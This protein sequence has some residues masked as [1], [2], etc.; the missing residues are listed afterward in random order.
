MH[1][2][3]STFHIR[4][5]T[6]LIAI[7]LLSVLL[8]VGVALLMGDQVVELPGIQDQISYHALALRLLS[9]HGYSFDAGWYPFTP[10]NTPTAHWS[11]AYPLYLAGVY[12]LFGIHPLA[13]R[14][15]QAAF[16]GVA[17]CLLIY[18][19]TRRVFGT[20][21]GLVAAGI[22]A[23][24]TYFVYYS[25][26]LMTESFFM[27]AALASLEMAYRLAEKPS[28]AR[29][30]LLGLCLGLAALLRQAILPF[31]PVLFAWLLW[32]NVRR[33]KRLSARTLAF[34]LIAGTVLIACIA[35]FTIRNYRVYGRFLLLNSNAGYAFYS[36]NNPALGS[37]W[38]SENSVAPIPAD[39]Q[40]RNEAEID[41]AL[42]RRGIGFIL[43]DPGRYARLTL[44]RVKEYFKFWPSPDSSLVSNLQRPLSFGLLLPLTLYGLYLARRQLRQWALPLLFFAVTAA[45]YLLSW[46]TARYRVPTDACLMP[47]AALALNDLYTRLLA[48]R[49]TK[50]SRLT[51]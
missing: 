21:V 2:R 9:G 32:T 24:Y 34:V 28:V 4:H 37:Y 29:A 11:F 20:Q 23:V 39:L 7:L 45:T 16:V 8:R 46:P 17:T 33:I 36:S 40:G 15:I 43:A 49:K 26:A 13:A 41:S 31:V 35:P 42:M 12:G 19:L 18:S 44:S 5:A 22:A 6:W 25:A 27:V 14:L 47:L 51:A 30:V 1:I 38:L 50:T 10:A 3:H 48:G